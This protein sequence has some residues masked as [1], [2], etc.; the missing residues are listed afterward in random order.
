MALTPEE[1]HAVA[2]AV[3]KAL[4]E[5]M[6]KPDE[7]DPNGDDDQD[8]IPNAD[9]PTPEGEPE[10]APA[11]APARM[12]R[13]R[14]ATQQRETYQPGPHRGTDGNPAGRTRQPA[15]PVTDSDGNV[16][17]TATLAR[18]QQANEQTRAELEAEQRERKALESRL[19]AT[20]EEVGTLTK[21]NRYNA[22]KGKL[23]ALVTDE[24]YLFEPEDEIARTID[25]DDAGFDKE[26]DRIKAN[27]AR[28]L[29]G[30]GPIRMGAGLN[31]GGKKREL[32]PD[33]YGKLQRFMDEK[34]ITNHTQAVVEYLAANPA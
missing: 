13:T 2:S 26:F 25:L 23:A 15:R 24:G 17:L 18:Y 1:I 6:D 30:Q 7:L 10:P 19:Q 14:Q 20:A 12:S 9:D 28:G 22:R 5:H 3:V 8:G 16:N 32:R 11:P 27:Y 31:G 4:I 34:K 29:A 33:E 21:L